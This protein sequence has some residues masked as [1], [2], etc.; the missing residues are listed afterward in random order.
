MNFRLLIFALV[1]GVAVFMLV[2][3]LLSIGLLWSY[4]I[5][6]PF[7]QEQEST[8]ALGTVIQFASLWGAPWLTW[9]FARKIVDAI[10]SNQATAKIIGLRIAGLTLIV[11][12]A[13]FLPGIAYFVWNPE[14]AQVGQLVLYGAADENTIGLIIGLL[15]GV[16]MFHEHFV[17][18][19]S[20]PR[21]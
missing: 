3:S 21:P 18:L 13:S 14:E 10:L 1:R 11:N 8:L 6:P 19:F 7:A 17:R 9:A 16:A 5:P 12:A 2:H 15:V 20:K 4:N